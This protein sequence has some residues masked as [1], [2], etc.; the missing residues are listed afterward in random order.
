MFGVNYNVY[1]DKYNSI[2]DKRDSYKRQLMGA[3]IFT[4]TTKTD[5]KTGEETTVKETI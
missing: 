3:D 2:I 1:E 5:E 4:V